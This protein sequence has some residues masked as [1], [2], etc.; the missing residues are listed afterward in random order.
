MQTTAVLLL[1]EMMDG[2]PLQGDEC[3]LSVCSSV[4]NADDVQHNETAQ[5][6]GR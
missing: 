3:E 1:V 5:R 4:H 2:P 6:G